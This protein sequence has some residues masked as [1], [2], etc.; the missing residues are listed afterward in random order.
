L[1][2]RGVHVA[3]DGKIVYG[4]EAAG[5]V[6]RAE[7]R[8]FYFSGDTNVFG[9]IKL[10]ADLYSPEL[11]FLPIGDL[12]T[13]GPKEAAAACRM[14]GVKTVIPM[15]FATFSALTGTP[16]ALRDLLKGSGIE[17][18]DLKPGETTSW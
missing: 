17:I 2:F 15:H 14:L 4:G 11:A 16:A 5:Y 9:D 10:I 13:M 3:D 12:F 6:V 7:G 8:T 18:R 1:P